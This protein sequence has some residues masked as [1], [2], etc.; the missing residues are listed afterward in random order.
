[1]ADFA[2]IW[3]PVTKGGY[4]PAHY[5]RSVRV[6]RSSGRVEAVNKA[7]S[8]AAKGCTGQHT[9]DGS[10]QQC[11]KE[12]MAGFSAPGSDAPSYVKAKK[13]RGLA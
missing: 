7:F 4:Y 5:F 2:K 6:S 1:M 3:K 8:A 10:F 9:S 13:Y 11:I 12:K